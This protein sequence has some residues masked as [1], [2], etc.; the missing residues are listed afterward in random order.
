MALT[1]KVVTVV[2]AQV[3]VQ[4]VLIQVNANGSLLLVVKGATKDSTGAQVGLPHASGIVDSTDKHIQA[5]MAL[6][7][8]AL[9]QDN[10]LEDSAPVI[11]DIDPA[12]ALA[13]AQKA[14]AKAQ[15]AATQG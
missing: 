9:Q 10:D 5:V 2:A 7:L 1:D 13:K 8:K 11:T 4:Q 12:K 14:L 6:A 15:A 3:A